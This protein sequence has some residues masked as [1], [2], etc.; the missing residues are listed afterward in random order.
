MNHRWSPYTFLAIVLLAVVGLGM[1]VVMQEPSQ[2]G[3]WIILVAILVWAAYDV[4]ALRRALRRLSDVHLYR[5]SDAW[6]DCPQGLAVCFLVISTTV[7]VALAMMSTGHAA[8]VATILAISAAYNRLLDQL[9]RSR[10][11]APIID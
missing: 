1:T 2:S 3:A 6:K 8:L 5:W 10:P 7:I 4:Y 11:P 9:G